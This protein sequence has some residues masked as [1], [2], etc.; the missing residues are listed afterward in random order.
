[1][2][3]SPSQWIQIR[4]A[5]RTA[6]S[7]NNHV[8]TFETACKSHSQTDAVAK[9]YYATALALRARASIAPTTKLSLANQ[10]EALLNAAT[11][12]QPQ[13]L[14][15][16]F[17]RYSFEYGT[18]SILNMKKNMQVDKPLAIKFAKSPSP[19]KDI[20]VKFFQKCTDLSETEKRDIK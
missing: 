19:I 10:A 3:P 20:A 17:L 5:Y 6:L 4:T 8:N 11:T 1:M 18:P 7:N 15:I 12:S 2:S 13:N 14:E 16:R 9:A